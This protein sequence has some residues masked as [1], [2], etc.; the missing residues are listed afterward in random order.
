VKFRVILAAQVE[1]TESALWYEDRQ[2]GLA[3]DYFTE[4]EKAFERIRGNP[5][6]MSRLE[7][8]SGPHEIRRCLMSRFP[9]AVIFL[10]NWSRESGC[11]CSGTHAPSAT[12]LAAA[13][14]VLWSKKVSETV[15]VELT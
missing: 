8:Y 10:I 5:Q 13:N 4:L 11:D 6:G 12:L 3:E 14:L 9:Y 15:Y 7:H 2:P 1:A